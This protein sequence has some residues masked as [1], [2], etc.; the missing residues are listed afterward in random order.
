MGYPV[1]GMSPSSDPKTVYNEF[2]VKPVGIKGYGNGVVTPHATFLALPFVFDEAVNNLKEFIKHYP[3]IYGEYG[4]YDA[5]DPLSGTIVYRYLALDQA[6]TFLGLANALNPG[7]LHKRF[8][9]DPIVKKGE[10][11]LQ[12]ENPLPN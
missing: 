12:A 7:K 4:F 6:M 11:L 3:N 5:V 8:Y 1:W 10:K 9:S 2:G